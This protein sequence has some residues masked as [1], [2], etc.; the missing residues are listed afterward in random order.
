MSAERAFVLY[1]TRDRPDPD[2]ALWML[3]SFRRRKMD[4]RLHPFH[5]PR[6]AESEAM[7]AQPHAKS[8]YSP[9]F[10][11]AY[12][13]CTSSSFHSTSSVLVHPHIALAIAGNS[14]L[15][16]AHSPLM[17]SH[18]SELHVKVLM[19]GNSSVGKSSLLARWSENQWVSEDE[20]SATIGVE[21]K[22][23]RIGRTYRDFTISNQLLEA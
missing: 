6:T 19:V 9:Q 4:G 3:M 16:V 21:V 1:C 23:R 15:H 2:D 13:S 11:G 12:L 10:H 5:W 18:L 14:S 17:Q 8:A 7:C 20:A 22:V